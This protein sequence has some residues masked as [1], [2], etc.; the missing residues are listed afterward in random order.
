MIASCMVRVLVLPDIEF[1]KIREIERPRLA[2]LFSYL[3]IKMFKTSLPINVIFS[4][5]LYAYG[6]F[7]ERHQE[8]S[9]NGI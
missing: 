9:S 8:V 6:L 3:A 7:E 4:L 1:G 2:N 5:I